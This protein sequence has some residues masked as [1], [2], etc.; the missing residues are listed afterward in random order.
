MQQLIRICAGSGLIYDMHVFQNDNH[1]AVHGVSR[2]WVGGYAIAM[3]L[4]EL[5]PDLD[6]LEHRYAYI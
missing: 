5:I 3:R 4:G 1:S 2:E 6:D